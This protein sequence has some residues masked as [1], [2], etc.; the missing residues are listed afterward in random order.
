MPKRKILVSAYACEPIKGSE[1]AVGWNW[2]LQL[3]KHNELHVITRCNNQESIEANL[4]NEL[5]HNITFHYYDTPL[6]FQ[7][8][9][10]KD[11]RL[12]LYNF[13]WQIG[14]VPFA[15]KIIKQH[16]IDYTM[17]LTFGSIW[18]PTF[19]PILK[20]AFIWGPIGGCECI[21]KQFLKVMPLSQKIVQCMRYFLNA[22]VI[23]NPFILLP[24]CRA[25]VILAR[26]YDTMN[27]IPRCFHKKTKV[28]LETAMDNSVFEYKKEK[29]P[30]DTVRLIISARLIAIKNISMAIKALKYISQDRKWHLT[31]I[32][33]GPEKDRIIRETHNDKLDEKVTIIPFMPRYEALKKIEESDIFIFPS[34][35]E[36]GSWALMEAMTI[37][38]PV[39]CLDWAGMKMITDDKSAIRLSITNP[40]QMERD[41]AVAICKLID[42]PELRGQM[43]YAGRERIKAVFN[44]E[45]KGIFMENLFKKLEVTK[46]NES[47]Q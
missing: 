10:K 7:R 39:I 30:T 21:P 47:Y 25:D 42:N 9:K 22:T 44:W 4:P 45:S 2:I 33:S 43:G 15:R 23:L 34:L 20:T 27:A 32:G 16:Q 13:L 8:I 31:I 37:G 6:L 24:A 14:I 19:L 29:N 28:I 11:K 1:P 40:E 46:G 35:K 26:T 18:M 3:A 17:H 12:Y 41:M 5:K 38:L 36:G